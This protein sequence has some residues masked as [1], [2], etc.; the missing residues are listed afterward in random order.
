MCRR[1]DGTWGPSGPPTVRITNTASA[2]YCLLKE[3]DL[4]SSE[5]GLR[6]LQSIAQGDLPAMPRLAAWPLVAMSVC[7]DPPRTV[8]EDLLNQ[9]VSWHIPGQGWG[10]ASSAYANLLGK[11]DRASSAIFPTSIVIWAIMAHARSGILSSAAYDAAQVA[12]NWIL[13]MPEQ[14]SGGFGWRPGET[15][16]PT[17]TALA[18][19]GVRW[20]ELDTAK[21]KR[22]QD[23]LGYLQKAVLASS[24][25]NIDIELNSGRTLNSDYK[26]YTP[27]WVLLA[28]AS[29]DPVSDVDLTI[30]ACRNLLRLQDSGSGG[31]KLTFDQPAEVWSTFNFFRALEEVDRQL[32]GGRILDLLLSQEEVK[33]EMQSSNKQSIYLSHGKGTD[34]AMAIRTLVEALGLNSIRTAD[35]PSLGRTIGIKVEENMRICRGGVFLFTGD[36]ST[37]V[38]SASQDAVSSYI[39]GRPN[40]AEE[41]GRGTSVWGRRFCLILK[42][43]G[44]DLPS[45]LQG[46]EYMD[47]PR[48]RIE[49]I[50]PRLISNLRALGFF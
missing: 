50:F 24:Q 23:A 6:F 49:V 7:E 41:F 18:L 17:A 39:E 42:E 38:T 19:L 10:H 8:V 9:L 3:S 29:Y 22:L 1:P 32:G 48:G 16:N 30:R 5:L 31:A 44:V 13:E 36:Q 35:E 45:N 46:I 14:T 21:L 4:L 33:I 11:P 27:A 25:N 37:S 43:E 34:A 2:C 40:V 15:S 26:F 12:A 28:L 47:F 20:A